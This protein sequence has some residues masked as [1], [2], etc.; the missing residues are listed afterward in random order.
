MVYGKST[1]TDQY[2]QW[3]SNH[4]TG[5]K[6][7]VYNTFAHRGQVV[8]HNQ[9]SLHKEIDHIRKALQACHLPNWTLNRLKQKFEQKPQT[10]I[11]PSSRQTQT[12][13]NTNNNGSTDNANNKNIVTVVPYIH[14]LDEKFKKTCKNKGIQAHFKGTNTVRTLLMAPKDEEDKLQKSGIIYKFKCPHI[15]CPEEYIY[16]SAGGIVYSLICIC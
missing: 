12:T 16:H 11:A 3:D 10:Y 9:L 14:R 2:L 5:A 4:F 8:S 13:N 6:C 7:S 15:N 1:H